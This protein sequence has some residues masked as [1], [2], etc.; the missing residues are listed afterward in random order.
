MTIGVYLFR[1]GVVKEGA[2]TRKRLGT[3]LLRI[4]LAHRFATE[5]SAWQIDRAA[6]GAR[7]VAAGPYSD[8][9]LSL[10]HSA[11]FMAVAISDGGIRVGI[12]LEHPRPRE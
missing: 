10:S 1:N 4:A 7:I 3:D 11:D 9:L 5:V 6:D 8:V 2:E 12:D